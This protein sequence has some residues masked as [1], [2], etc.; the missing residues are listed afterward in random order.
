[1]HP[2]VLPS[3]N[4]IR[5]FAI[6]LV[7][8]NHN[9]CQ[10]IGPLQDIFVVLGKA[11]VPL[12]LLLTGYLNGNKTIEDYYVYGK[13]KRCIDIIIAYGVL[14]TLCYFGVSFFLQYRL[15]YKKLYTE[16]ALLSRNRKWMVY[17]YVDR[18]ILYYTAHQLHDSRS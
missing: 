12:F 6:F 11:G 4:L 8:L 18:V 10:N 5:A 2:S 15:Q 9:F 7:M 1:M 14:G 13:W 3:L 16:T 17:Q